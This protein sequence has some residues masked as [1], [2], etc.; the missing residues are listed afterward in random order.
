M[1]RKYLIFVFFLS[2]PLYAQMSLPQ[3]QFIASDVALD[4]AVKSNV[5]TS[6][7]SPFH[8]ILEITEI[9]NADPAFKGRVELF[10]EDTQ[11][12]RLVLDSPNFGQTLIVNG[13]QVIE[14][15]RGDFYPNW[16]NNFVIALTDPM[17]RLNDLRGRQDRIAIGPKTFSC[18]RRDDKPGGITDQMTWAQICFGGDE[19][20]LQFAID[21]T[22]NMEFHNFKKFEKKQIARTYVSETG[23]HS[24]LQ[25]TLTTL[26]KW[27]PDEALLAVTT[28]TAPSDRIL[29]RL[30]S[31]LTEESMLESAPDDVVWP[32]VRSGKTEGY[33]I[34]QA[35]TDRTGQ[36][37][38]TSKHNSDNG[39]LESF[40]REVA[41]KY[42][43]KPLVVDGA[44]QQMVMP[45]VL[46]F[47][48]K[49][50]GDP[51]PDLDDAT[52]RNMITGCSLPHKIDD[53]ASAGRQIVITF[54]V[55]DDGRLGTVGSSD[56]KIPVPTL[57]Q[58]FSACHFKQYIQNGKPTVYNAHLTV[59]A[60]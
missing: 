20:Q 35:T 10:W 49:I 51:I 2:V 30:V 21:F 22:Y 24:R 38:E 44:P 45:L 31:T 33:M 5:L 15:N 3:P 17:P 28:P 11:K 56:H 19:P 23:D 9:K 50:G 53:P 39:G 8:A 47:T 32:E 4:K 55:W 27:E 14:S 34:V 13:A 54:F 46:H 42:K 58:Q 57:F 60:Q 1:L 40:G 41:L 36:V 18:V 59:T 43:F 48:T 16:L 6:G 29:T 26:E 52:T 25:G 7:G 12:Y 37:R